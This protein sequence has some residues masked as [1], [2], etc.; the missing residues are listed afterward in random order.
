MGKRNWKGKWGGGDGK[1]E[2]RNKNFKIII[3]EQL[4]KGSSSTIS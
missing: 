3:M 4:I 2:E 1:R